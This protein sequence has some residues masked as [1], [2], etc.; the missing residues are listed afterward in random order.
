MINSTA[1]DPLNN[2]LF[3]AMEVSSFECSQS[4]TV[5]GQIV[6]VMHAKERNQID[7]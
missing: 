3:K 6:M 5:T 4:L 7:I 1:F 2:K